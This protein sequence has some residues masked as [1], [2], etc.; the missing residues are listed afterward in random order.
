MGRFAHLPN[1]VTGSVG[2]VDDRKQRLHILGRVQYKSVVF[3]KYDICTGCKDMPFFPRDPK[4][5]SDPK[6]PE[7]GVSLISLSLPHYL[8][9]TL[10]LS[11]S[12]SP[13]LPLTFSSLV[14]I[15]RTPR[16]RGVRRSGPLGHNLSLIGQILL[17]V[18]HTSTHM[19]TGTKTKRLCFALIPTLNRQSVLWFHGA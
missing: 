2:F 5:P 9:L 14:P 15:L 17:C 4:M 11:L 7:R 18:W 13:F 16:S 8:S 6:M 19:C 1:H 3:E 12:L 10:S